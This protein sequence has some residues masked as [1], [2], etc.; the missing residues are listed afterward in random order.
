MLRRV[1]TYSVVVA[2]HII[3]VRRGVR[4]SA[5]RA[6]ARPLRPP[7]PS[8]GAAGPARRPV[9][10]QQ[11][12]HRAGHGARAR[13]SASTW[14]ATATTGT[15]RSS[16]SGSAAIAIIAVVG[17]GVIVPALKRL[18]ALDPARREYDRVYRRYMAAESFLG[19]RRPARDLRYGGQAVLVDGRVALMSNSL[20]QLLTE[21]AAEHA[22]RPALKLDDTVLNYAV[23]NEARD[24][25]RGPAEGEGR[26]A[27]RPRRDHAAR[28]SRTSRPSTTASCAR[29]ASS[30]R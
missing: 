23:L 10:A 26:R 5:D 15:S 30:C 9:P 6:A 7:S 18:A 14:R 4:A 1:S 25:R 17:G 22:D 28:T 13:R 2:L 24:A 21:T 29:A 20:A 8:G 12:A 3:A 19:A 16:A 11:R 27:R